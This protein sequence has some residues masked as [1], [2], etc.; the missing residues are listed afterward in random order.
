MV[1]TIKLKKRAKELGIN[2]QD[3]ADE[4]GLKQSSVSLKLNNVRPMTLSECEALAKL[5][6]IPGDDLDEYF[7]MGYVIAMEE[8]EKLRS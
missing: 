8:E 7:F 6:R 3:L 5:L 1:N 4:L 2:Q